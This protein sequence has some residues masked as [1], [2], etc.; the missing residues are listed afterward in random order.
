MTVLALIPARGGSKG[1]PRKN[2]RLVGGRSLIERAVAAVRGSGVVDRVLVSTDDEEIAEAARQAGAEVPFLR[3]PELASDRAP[4]GPVI[5][6]AITAFEAYADV[7]VKTLVFTEPTVPFRNAEHVAGAVTRYRQGDCRSVIT[8]CP[9]ERKPENIFAK[10][11]DGHLARYIRDPRQTFANR[12]DMA[13]LCCL[14]SG[15]YV[16]GRDTYMATGTLVVEPVGFVEMTVIESVNID[17]EIDLMLAEI[18]A[19]RYGL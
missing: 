13:D 14:S 8:V 3:P 10:G 12:Q 2:L 1:V 5:Q 4:M 16:I 15:V 11:R 7:T 19:E 18:I 9:L 6:H 17:E